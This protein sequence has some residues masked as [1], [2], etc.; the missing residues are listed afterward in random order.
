MGVTCGRVANRTSRNQF[1]LNGVTHKVD[2]YPPHKH[3]LH[4]GPK[5]FSFLVW[6]P[7]LVN[8][9]EFLISPTSVGVRLGL[10][11][12][13][14]DMGYP[15]N[16]NV[17]ATFE[18]TSANELIITYD[19]TAD[20]ETPIMMTSHSY[21]NLSGG[22]KRDVT[23]HELK[24]FANKFVEVD[25]ELIPTGKVREV[26]GTPMDFREPKL[27][28]ENIHADYDILKHGNDGYDLSFLV[29][30]AGQTASSLAPAVRV[31]EQ[32]SGRVMEVRTDQLCVQ[33]YTGNHL[34]VKGKK[35]QHYGRYQGICFEAH[36]YVNA[37]NMPSVPSIFVKPGQ[38]YKSVT[39]HK[40]FTE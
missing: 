32:Q 6:E 27:V 13:D 40:F 36:G 2:P 17:T 19:A 34:D 16:V 22:G 21:F 8:N 31:K 28:G 35:G 15:G 25:S 3:H 14:G 7:R 11:S 24:L 33:V 10:L 4:G 1:V 12:P 9:T 5:G 37:A 18:V 38:R 30:R 29:D 23:G 26:V 39:V 20:R